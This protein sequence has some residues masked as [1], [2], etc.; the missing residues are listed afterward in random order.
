MKL[1]LGELHNYPLGTRFLIDGKGIFYYITQKPYDLMVFDGKK[2]ILISDILGEN[3]ENVK[4]T[5][6]G[7]PTLEIIRKIMIISFAYTLS[8]ELQSLEYIEKI[9]PKINEG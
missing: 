6:K 9:L 1:T 8:D 5:Y 3:F 2:N 7:E 4:I